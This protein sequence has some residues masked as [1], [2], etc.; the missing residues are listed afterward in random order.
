MLT[1][2]VSAEN[3]LIWMVPSWHLEANY[4]AEKMRVEVVAGEN[5]SV[6][7][8]QTTLRSDWIV[9]LLDKWPLAALWDNQSVILY[10]LNGDSLVRQVVL[11]LFLDCEISEIQ[12][13]F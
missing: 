9:W 12:M 2:E 7:L 11:V 3:T 13:L 4:S 6:H 1:R 10:L 8:D 5:E